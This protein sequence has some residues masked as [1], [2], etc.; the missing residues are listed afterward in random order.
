M[1]GMITILQVVRVIRG[2]SLLHVL[3]SRKNGR[4]T[5]GLALVDGDGLNRRYP[6]TD[7]RNDQDSK[8]KSRSLPLPFRC[9]E[10]LL[11]PRVSQSK[12]SEEHPKHANANEGA[13]QWALD[14][15]DPNF[16]EHGVKAATQC[17]Y[18]KNKDEEGTDSNALAGR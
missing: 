17:L 6:N 14:G 11:R 18:R 5:I 12:R 13:H 10:M 3:K 4:K 8:Q 2:P 16:G 9:R 15:L 1:N 7:G